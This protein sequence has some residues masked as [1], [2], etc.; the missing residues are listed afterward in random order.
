M[1]RKDSIEIHPKRQYI[2]R[3]LLTG[4]RTLREIA[5]KYGISIS[6]LHR[7]KAHLIKAIREAKELERI[8]QGKT[9]FE[10]FNEMVKE[11][12]QKYRGTTEQL[13][14]GWF[15]EWR[16]MLELAFKL[17]IEEERRRERQVYSDVSPG[18]LAIINKEYE[19]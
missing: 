14:V 12:E 13:Q 19:G 15:R 7:H 16:A 18:V 3:M 6:A 8:K 5:G 1:P 2:N 17:G 9:G 10:Q 11:A 4:K